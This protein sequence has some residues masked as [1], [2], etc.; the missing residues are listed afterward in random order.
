[1]GALLGEYVRHEELGDLHDP[2]GPGYWKRLTEPIPS[3]TLPSGTKTVRL[4]VGA[5]NTGGSG[6]SY[7]DAVQ[8]Q[9]GTLTQFV[10]PTTY[11]AA[12]G[13]AA[14]YDGNGKKVRYTYNETGNPLLVSI[15]PNGTL[16]HTTEFKWVDNQPNLLDSVQSPVQYEL[17]ISGRVTDYQY[18]SNGNLERVI[19]PLGKESRYEYNSVNDLVTYTDPNEVERSPSVPQPQVV[20]TYGAQRNAAAVVNRLGMV[21]AQNVD[22]TTCKGCIL[23]ATSP[24]SRADNLLSNPSFERSDLSGAPVGWN[25]NPAV[26]LIN[27]TEIDGGKVLQISST[28]LWIE[29]QHSRM[30]PIEANT[31]YT[32][33]FYVKAQTPLLGKVSQG[34][35]DFLDASGSVVGMS[36]YT[37]VVERGEE[38]NRVATKATP[39]DVPTGAVSMR[40]VLATTTAPSGGLVH[41]DAVQLEKAPY[42]STFNALE[43]PGFERANGMGNGPDQWISTGSNA[44]WSSSMFF[45]TGPTSDQRSVGFT[46]PSGSGSWESAQLL[47]YQPG[48]PLSF[49]ALAKTDSLQ[50]AD[51]RL[52]LKWYDGSQQLLTGLSDTVT[53]SATKLTG[54]HDWTRLY[55]QVPIGAVANAVYVRP[56]LVLQASGTTLQGSAYFDAA[57]LELVQVATEYTY[58]SSGQVAHNNW[59]TR[60]R[61]PMGDVIDFEYDDSGFTTQV[62][63][64]GDPD[65]AVTYSPDYLQRLKSVESPNGLVTEYNYTG[66]GELLSMTHTW[67]ENGMQSAT[68]TFAYDERGLVTEVA[69]PAGTQGAPRVTTYVYDAAGNLVA[70]ERPSGATVTLGYDMAN[71][72]GSRTF[73]GSIY[74]FVY[75]GNGNLKQVQNGTRTWSYDYDA[76]NRMSSVNTVDGSQLVGSVAYEYDANSNITKRTTTVASSTNE[77]LMKYDENDNL[78]HV[79]SSIAGGSIV[80]RFEYHEHG[81]VAKRVVGEQVYSTMTYDAAGR[82]VKQQNV[83]VDGTYLGSYEYLYDQFGNRIEEK[84]VTPNATTTTTFEYDQ[85]GQLVKAGP[86]EYEYTQRGNRKSWFDGTVTTYYCYNTADQLLY[87]GPNSACATSNFAYDADGNMTQNGSGADLWAYEYDAESRLIRA[88]KNGVEVVS[89]LYDSAGRRIAKLSPDGTERRY[90]YDGMSNRVLYESDADGDPVVW[91]TWAG[92]R[93][94]SQTRGANTY[95]YVYNG[96][97]DVVSLYDSSGSLQVGYAYDEWGKPT[98]QSG[99]PVENPYRY[100]GYV[101]DEE[102]GLYYL[103]ARYYDPKLSR[104]LTQD[105]YDGHAWQPW[106]LNRYAYA[107]NSAVN[108]IDPTGHCPIMISEGDGYGVCPSSTAVRSNPTTAVTLDDG[109]QVLLYEDGAASVVDRNGNPWNGAEGSGGWPDFIVQEQSAARVVVG[110]TLHYSLGAMV[111]L[112]IGTLTSGLGLLPASGAGIGGSVAFDQTIAQV[113]DAPSFGQVDVTLYQLTSVTRENLGPTCSYEWQTRTISFYADGGY[114]VGSWKRDGWWMRCP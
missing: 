63:P 111:G 90:H 86:N 77:N 55:I 54:T 60:V 99:T 107:G 67:T 52:T 89:Y 102:T 114:D 9:E 29:V 103:N 53:T 85:V 33:S 24:L 71:R 16:H 87:A 74:S 19:D 12:P 79:T 73:D 26:T 68:V 109:V 75:D 45:D 25:T 15:D 61:N 94:V 47:P 76:I 104:F 108:F 43:N 51:A 41:F 23:S 82:L 13:A 20:L 49:T 81:Q 22:L 96:H 2:H 93:L 98:G 64:G 48:R 105:A 10:A 46:S 35:I 66:N 6:S 50:N 58:G 59:V 106:M 27:N 110:N 34:R 91:Y 38:W 7:F 31:T 39:S 65:Y 28:G 21:S 37:N 4:K 80:G 44:V 88:L 30:I 1:M 83:A 95:Y 18:D 62:I 3:E 8:F 42:I 11:T 56:A 40:I 92:N 100:S 14:L 69:E 36:R 84:V 78:L 70:I 57:R 113:V 97:G 5:S 32:L 112:T 72:L 101:W 17:G